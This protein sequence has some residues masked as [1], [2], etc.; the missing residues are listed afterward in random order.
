[1]GNSLVVHLFLSLLSL[2]RTEYLSA[3]GKHGEKQRRILFI[4]FFMNLQQYTVI[5]KLQNY[6]MVEFQPP[7]HTEIGPFVSSV[8]VS[9]KKL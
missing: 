7:F 1:M 4:Y 5:T 2:L 6:T 8:A 9:S 3:H